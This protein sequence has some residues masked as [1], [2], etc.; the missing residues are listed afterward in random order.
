MRGQML[1]KNLRHHIE[2]SHR[3]QG[4]HANEKLCPDKDQRWL[5]DTIRDD[6]RVR[7]W[8][9]PVFC[10]SGNGCYLLYRIDL[11]NDDDSLALVKRILETM[12]EEFS[13]DDA[14]WSLAI[15]EA[16]A[17][18]N[19]RI[20]LKLDDGT[21]A[22]FMTNCSPVLAGEG[23]AQGVLISFD[24]VTELEQKEIELQISKEEAEAAN[25]SK[26]EFLAHMSHEI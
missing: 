9:E 5:A 4:I 16:T 1:E 10:M 7:G 14:P 15:K 2:E 24:D 26:S 25:K 17:K 11:P 8:S 20:R 23:K 13:N 19:M 22:T 6:M 12:V 21:S 3:P 18:M